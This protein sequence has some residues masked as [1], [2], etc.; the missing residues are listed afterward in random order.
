VAEWS[1]DPG[2]EKFSLYERAGVKEYWIVHPVEKILT[3]FS[4]DEQ[5]RYGRPERYSDQDKAPVG[6][7]EGDLVIDLGLVF[8]D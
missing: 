3:I 8:R 7:F 6:L 4:P 1:R 2:K 5:A